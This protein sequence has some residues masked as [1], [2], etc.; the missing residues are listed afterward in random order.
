M[1]ML[2][3]VGVAGWLRSEGHPFWSSANALVSVT[4]V[5][6]IMMKLYLRLR[7]GHATCGCQLA[8]WLPTSQIRA[9]LH[10]LPS[11]AASEGDDCVCA[12]NG[13]YGSIYVVSKMMSTMMSTLVSVMV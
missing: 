10:H 4:G 7:G 11:Q 6:Q 8:R 12:C 1:V 2:R 5:R 3:G 9:Y 13:V